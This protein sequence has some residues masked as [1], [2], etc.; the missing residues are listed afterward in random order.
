[1][2]FAAAGRTLGQAQHMPSAGVTTTLQAHQQAETLCA[3]A[4]SGMGFEVLII[5]LS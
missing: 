2:L 1:L 4:M 5:S 3:M